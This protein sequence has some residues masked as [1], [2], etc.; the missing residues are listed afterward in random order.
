M[1]SRRVRQPTR[2]KFGVLRI[3]ASCRR[4]GAAAADRSR[5]IDAELEAMLRGREE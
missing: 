3:I 5:K 2:R 1:I 4:A